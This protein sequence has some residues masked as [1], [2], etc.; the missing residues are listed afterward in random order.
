MSG[1]TFTVKDLAQYLQRHPRNVRKLL[2]RFQVEPTFPA[3]SQ[4]R[5]TDA[6]LELLGNRMRAAH[7]ELRAKGNA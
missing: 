2:R 7:V 1:S 6:D 3:R 4:H 5:Y